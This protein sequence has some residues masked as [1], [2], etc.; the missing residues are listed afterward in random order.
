MASVQTKTGR[1]PRQTRKRW[2]ELSTAQRRAAVAGAV[3]Q[4]TLLAAAQIDIA[5]RLPG[6]IRGSKLMWRLVV[7]INF[8]G[9]LAYFACGRRKSTRATAAEARSP[10]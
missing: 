7:L 3:V 2:S 4:L 6:E 10:H 1:M 9:P 8:I 5:R